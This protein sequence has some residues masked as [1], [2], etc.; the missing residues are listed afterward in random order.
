MAEYTPELMKAFWDTLKEL[1]PDLNIIVLID[2][3]ETSFDVGFL[4]EQPVAEV[5]FVL[6]DLIQTLALQDGV[7]PDEVIIA[8]RPLSEFMSKYVLQA[9]PEI[10]S[11][12]N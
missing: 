10:R 3:A 5:I 4:T 2:N 7:N 1:R 6:S 9:H 8:L 12:L 11:T